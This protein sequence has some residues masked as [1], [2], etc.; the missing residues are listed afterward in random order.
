MIKSMKK[1]VLV[2]AIAG[3]VAFGALSVQTLLAST[4]NVEYVN[5]DKDPKKD[6]KTS[7]AKADTKSS[8]DGECVPKSDCTTKSSCCSKSS[9]AT[10]KEGPDKK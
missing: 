5:F 8:K 4:S 1:L 2:I 6:K 9:G 10:S 7:E 3:F